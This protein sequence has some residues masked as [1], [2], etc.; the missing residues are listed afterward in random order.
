[1][2]VENFT[3]VN[4]TF[5]AGSL[6]NDLENEKISWWCIAGSVYGRGSALESGPT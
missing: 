3:K 1:M 4:L 2:S 5:V 6:G